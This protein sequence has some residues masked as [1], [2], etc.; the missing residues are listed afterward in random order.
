ML[1]S[2][3]LAVKPGDSDAGRAE[4]S[5][6]ECR[7]HSK[8][9]QSGAQ[10]RAEQG[11]LRPPVKMGPSWGTMRPYFS[12]SEVGPWKNFWCFS[13][14]FFFTTENTT[15]KILGITRKLQVNVSHC[16]F[17]HQL[18]KPFRHICSPPPTSWDLQDVFFP[19]PLSCAH[20]LHLRHPH[21]SVLLSQL[22]IVIRFPQA[23]SIYLVSVIFDT[24]IIPV[25]LLLSL[26]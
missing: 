21:P 12:S 8:R 23:I 5:C 1:P 10:N 26:S 7:A 6:W 16:I 13:S 25:N 24:G 20:R 3:H 11:R 15:S 9:V 19:G 14:Y 22:W 4:A 17:Q 18:S 2:T